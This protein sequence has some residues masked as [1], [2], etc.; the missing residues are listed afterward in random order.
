[1]WPK[2]ENEATAFRLALAGSIP[3]TAIDYLTIAMFAAQVLLADYP[4]LIVARYKLA[5]PPASSEA[6]LH[7]VGRRRGLLRASGVVDLHKAAELLVH[8]FR[9]GTLG[10]ISLEVAPDL[11]EK[12]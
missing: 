3:D 4:A 6:L 10:R 5:G 7:E 9:A 2:I 11:G 8:E 1:M 12:T